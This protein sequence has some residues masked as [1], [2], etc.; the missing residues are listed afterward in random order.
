MYWILRAK[1]AHAYIYICLHMVQWT[2]VS[3]SSLGAAFVILPNV[4]CSLI[5]VQKTLAVWLTCFRS[6]QVFVVLP[7]WKQRLLA[8]G[9]WASRVISPCWSAS[10]NLPPAR[11]RSW[12]P[13]APWALH[14]WPWSPAWCNPP[15]GR[16]TLGFLGRRWTATQTQ[17]QSTTVVHLKSLQCTLFAKIGSV[18]GYSDSGASYE[19]KEKISSVCRKQWFKLE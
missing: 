19:G 17:T 4:F 1:S 3:L 9:H 11:G 15:A 12:L 14:Q 13:G 18:N 7:P 8:L 5:L 2:M 6:Q 16:K 10:C